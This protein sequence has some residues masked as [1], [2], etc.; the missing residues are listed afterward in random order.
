MCS[1]IYRDLKFACDQGL[2]LANA[3]HLLYL[4]TPYDPV[5]TIQPNW[6]IYDRQVRHVLYEEAITPWLLFARDQGR[7]LHNALHS[8][9]YAGSLH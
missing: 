2:V 6:N 4:V 8:L 7:V 5:E 9:Y 3:L 1:T